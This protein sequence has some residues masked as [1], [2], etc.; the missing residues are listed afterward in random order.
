MLGDQI[1]LVRVMR[2]ALMIA[3]I[4]GLALAFPNVLVL[5]LLRTAT[6][7][8][9]GPVKAAGLVYVGDTWHAGIRRQ[10][11]SDLLAA[12]SMGVAVATAGAAPVAGPP[13]L[14]MP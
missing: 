8:R 13:A 9:P 14:Q 1:G 11:L 10:A 7:W 2:I 5:A 6:G 3:G 12:T 4:A